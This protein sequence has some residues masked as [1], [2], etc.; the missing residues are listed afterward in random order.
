MDKNHCTK[1]GHCF[2]DFED[3]KDCRY[4]Q[5]SFFLH[6]PDSCIL[7]FNERCLSGKALNEVTNENQTA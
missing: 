7:R 1:E 3:Q 2:A 4:Y 5:R 6:I